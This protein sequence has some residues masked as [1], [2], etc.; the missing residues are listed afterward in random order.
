MVGT[1]AKI[2]NDLVEFGD[3][4]ILYGRLGSVAKF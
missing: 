3:P 1:M 4:I 2:D